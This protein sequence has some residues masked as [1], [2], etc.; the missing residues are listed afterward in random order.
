[1]TCE[2]LGNEELLNRELVVRQRIR[3]LRLQY[4]EQERGFLTPVDELDKAGEIGKLEVTEK[5]SRAR[6]EREELESLNEHYL[7]EIRTRGLRPL[8]WRA[9]EEAS[10]SDAGSTE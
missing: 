7:G 4:E 8:P 2:T 9:D 1:M 3:E 10:G 6:Q 5:L